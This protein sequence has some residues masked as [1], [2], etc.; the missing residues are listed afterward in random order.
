MWCRDALPRSPASPSDWLFISGA[1]P[2]GCERF[3]PVAPSTACSDAEVESNATAPE[4]EELRLS[5]QAHDDSLAGLDRAVRR[6]AEDLAHLVGRGT[7][8]DDEVLGRVHVP[9]LGALG[10]GDGNLDR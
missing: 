5:L 8:R 9:G 10:A 3:T 4:G 7:V 6:A 2:A 1:G